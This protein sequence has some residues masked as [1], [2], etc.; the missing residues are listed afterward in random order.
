MERRRSKLRAQ[1]EIY[2]SEAAEVENLRTQRKGLHTFFSN[3]PNQTTAES[4]DP[5]RGM[6]DRLD[7][8]LCAVREY[9]A[10]LDTTNVL[11]RLKKGREEMDVRAQ[12]IREGMAEAD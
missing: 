11:E 3:H 6:T 10:R 7:W 2:E 1:M 12:S 8:A 9:L 5:S 4:S